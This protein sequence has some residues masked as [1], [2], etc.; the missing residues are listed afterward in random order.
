MELKEEYK[1]LSKDELRIKIEQHFQ[2]GIKNIDIPTIV[3]YDNGLTTM[4]GKGYSFTMNTLNYTK[5]VKK[6]ID[7]Y[8]NK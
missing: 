2:E 3:H 4:V 8:L 1:N 6:I 7:E 5:M